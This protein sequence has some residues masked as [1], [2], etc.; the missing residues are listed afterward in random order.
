MWVKKVSLKKMQT[1]LVLIFQ[2]Y[3]MAKIKHE[4]KYDQHKV[5]AGQKIIAVVLFW[6]ISHKFHLGFK[7]DQKPT[8]KIIYFK[9]N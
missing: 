9:N 2:L 8:K 6:R 5:V 7:C 3:S 1:H 4:D